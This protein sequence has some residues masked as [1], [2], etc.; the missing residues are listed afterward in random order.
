MREGWRWLGSKSSRATTAVLLVALA[1]IAA[2]VLAAPVEASAQN[3]SG[4]CSMNVFPTGQGFSLGPHTVQVSMICEALPEGS[5]Q[6]SYEGLRITS[7]DPLA[8]FASLETG[9]CS[10][11]TGG[12]ECP[13]LLGETS[14]SAELHG[15]LRFQSPVCELGGFGTTVG[16]EYMLVGDNGMTQWHP[17][18]VR[19]PCAGP[20]LVTGGSGKGGC[21]KHDFKMKVSIAA[22]LRQLLLEA[23]TFGGEAP[24]EEPQFIA[25]LSRKGKKT[26]SEPRLANLKYRSS[27]EG[28]KIKVPAGDLASGKYEVRVYLELNS[29]DDYPSD[30]EKFKR[31]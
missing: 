24:E 17:I 30:I 20:V 25:M 12:V 7:N 5:D 2:P 18:S 11:G 6:Y 26:S 3:G 21:A 22:E 19:G 14:S 10:A 27:L 4:L 31:C 29:P 1:V 8:E 28:F 13:L 9:T 15:D 16:A 23:V